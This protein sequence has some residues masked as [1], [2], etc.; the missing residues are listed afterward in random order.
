MLQAA[1]SLVTGAPTAHRDVP[2]AKVLGGV[3]AAATA[4]AVLQ[5]HGAIGYS[6]EYDLQLLMKRAWGLS[7]IWGDRRHHL[8]LV[9]ATMTEN[10]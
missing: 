4:R 7:R 9:A 10:S 5:T 1:Y 3:A 2:M 6:W 8:D